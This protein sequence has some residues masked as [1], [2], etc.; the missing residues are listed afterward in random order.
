MHQNTGLKSQQNIHY[1]DPYHYMATVS[2]HLSHMMLSDHCIAIC[3]GSV[4][5]VRAFVIDFKILLLDSHTVR[6]CFMVL[7]AKCRDYSCNYIH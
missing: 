5:T 7:T 3:L 2:K 6:I 4:S 1:H